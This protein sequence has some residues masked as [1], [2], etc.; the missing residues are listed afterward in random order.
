MSQKSNARKSQ[1]GSVSHHEMKR[2]ENNWRRRTSFV[3]SLRT[4]QEGFGKKEP[5]S[6]SSDLP[7]K[8]DTQPIPNSPLPHSLEILPKKRS[9]GLVM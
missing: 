3:E 4:P 1:R 6:R 8:A 7:G 5:A 2:L 9:M